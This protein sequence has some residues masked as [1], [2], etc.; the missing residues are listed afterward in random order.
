[1]KGLSPLL[2]SFYKRALL[3]YPARLRQ[4]YGQ[5]ILQTF[6]DA[7][8]DR[9]NGTAGF[10]LEMYKDLLKSSCMEQMHMLREHVMK[11][12]MFFYALTLGLI[13]TVLG[14]TATL[15]LQQM[16]RREANQPQAEM[17]NFYAS[18][19]ATGA[20]PDESIPPGYVDLERNLEPF[21]VFYN[22]QGKP[23][24]ST[25]YIDQSIPILP[26]GVV[27]YIRSHGSDTFTW[28]P[29]TA[30]RIAVVAQ[31]VTGSHA[32]IVLAGRSLRLVQRDESIL[33]RI[34]FFGWLI[35]VV[36]LIAGAALLNRAQRMR[37]VVT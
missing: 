36:L 14:G 27:D 37:P 16:L 34:A 9:K 31:R 19:I 3:L 29:R 22:E 30:V 18:E 23:E 12:P 4:E 28:E 1:M 11:Q 35:L 33:Y 17:A 24:A 25:G 13:L 10:W 7:R 26:P 5:Q 20:A 2:F 21:V 8:D 15:T 6:R 32:G